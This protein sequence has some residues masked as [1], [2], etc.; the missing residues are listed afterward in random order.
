MTS[1]EIVRRAIHFQNP[2]RIPCNYDS[3]RTPCRECYGDDILWCFAK[4]QSRFNEAGDKVDERGCVWKSMGETFGEP[5]EFPLEEL[6]EY[7]DTPLPD[8]DRA[9]RYDEMRRQIEENKGEKYMMA[10]MPTGIFQIMI[11]LFGFEDFMC[12]IAGNTEE[13]ARFASNL[14]D[15]CIRCIHRIA[16]AGADGIILIEDMGLQDRMMI[17]PT[18]WHDIYAPLYTRMFAAAHQRGLDVISH[19]CGHIVSILDDYIACGLDVIQM[20]QQD[21][22]GLE[23]LHQFAGK[24][25]FFCPL[26]IQTTID[27]DRKAIFDRAQK[28]VDC[29]ATPA[30]GFMSKT[31]PQP[32]AVHITDRYMR[33][34]TDAFAA[35]SRT[36]YGK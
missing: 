8:F 11:H 4:S 15:L 33:D 14:T 35:A 23:T 32:D 22:M 10:M 9:D 1:R 30:G 7:A 36:L 24:V 16:D 20:D 2:S 18:M 34:M 25:C 17:S 28:M 27:F 26:D 12:Q 5:T 19:T 21:N 31:Y 29:L 13:F 3:N 6:E